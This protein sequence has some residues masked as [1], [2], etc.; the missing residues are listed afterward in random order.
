[1]GLLYRQ[2]ENSTFILYI[3]ATNLYGYAMSQAL[4]NSYFAW[5]SEEE[6]RAAEI[7]LTGTAETRDAFSKIDPE[8]LGTY[9][10]LKVDLI[11]PSEI[12]FSDDNYPMAPQM[13]NL[14]TEML[15]ET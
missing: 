11:Y 10:I 13:M 2:D 5:L 14:Q 7:A 9:N 8:M 4:P 12:H 3:D 15:S 6:F 1:M